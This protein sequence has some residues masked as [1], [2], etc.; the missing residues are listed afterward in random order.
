M[1]D[2]SFLIW[3]NVGLGLYSG[4]LFTKMVIQFGL[5][6]HPARFT[7]YLISACVTAFF[8]GKAAMGLGLISPWEWIRWQPLPLVAA[9][10]ALLLQIIISVGEYDLIQQKVVSRIPLMAGLLCFAFFPSKA[11]FFFWGSI[12]AGC[13]FLSISIG[14]ARYQKRMYFKMA[15]FLGLFG[16]LQ[17]TEVYGLNVLG[18]LILFF[19]LF[20]FFLL[21]QAFGVAALI[22][23]GVRQ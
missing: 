7:A 22:N 6:N 12:A 2:S 3:V 20:Y 17:L 19:A 21:E 14:K 15:L 4:I 11:E 9:S 10:V 13:I 16:L 1:M 5:P 23:R 8:C 18:E